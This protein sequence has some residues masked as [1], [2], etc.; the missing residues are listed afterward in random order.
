[1]TQDKLRTLGSLVDLI[2][3]TRNPAESDP[4][5][6]LVLLEHIEKKTGLVSLCTLSEADTKSSKLFFE[7]GDIVFSKIRPNLRK[8]FVATTHGLAS[9]DAVILR[10]KDPQ[11]SFLLALILRSD[12]VAKRLE[13]LTSGGNL[14][15]ISSQDLLSVK[16]AWPNDT[17]EARSLSKIAEKIVESRHILISINESI[18]QLER[19]LLT[20]I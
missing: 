10:P 1:M 3:D 8:V 18:N 7:S 14:P 17:Q 13:Q 4:E 2:R 20:R 9:S 12:Y 6:R 15:R 16:L 5:M 19:S 11:S